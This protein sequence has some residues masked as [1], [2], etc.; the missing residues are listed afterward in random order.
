[1]VFSTKDLLY[2]WNKPGN[3]YIIKMTYNV[4]L[5]RRLNQQRLVEE[6]GLSKDNYWGYFALNDQEFEQILVKG[7][8]Y[9]SLIID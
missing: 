1:S 5:R 7:D 6:V 2:Y 9:E 8:V 4:A 3:V